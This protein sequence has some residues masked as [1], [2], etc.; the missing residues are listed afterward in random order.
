VYVQWL[1]SLGS[2]TRSRPLQVLTTTPP[3]LL[4]LLQSPWEGGTYKL[5]MEFSDEY[6][7]RPPKCKFS[8]P[9]FHPNVFPSGTVCLSILNEEKDWVP[10]ITISNI[11]LGIQDL[12]DNP[13]LADPAQREAFILCRDNN[14]EYRVRVKALARIYSS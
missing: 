9:L 10:T 14:E 8:P 11:L 1:R 13:N 6:P 5:E 4:S 2:V 12:L 3:P 7:A